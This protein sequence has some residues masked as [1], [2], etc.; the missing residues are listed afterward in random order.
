[1][2]D[3]PRIVALVPMKGH[4]ERVPNKNFR[5]FHGKPLYRWIV[6]SLLE[7]PEIAEVIINTDARETF[8]A[9]GVG[10]LPRVRL[11]DRPVELRGDFVSMNKVLGD[12]VA[13]VPADIY[14]M[15]HS[16]NPLLRSGT[17]RSAIAKYREVLADGTGDSVFAVNRFQTRFYRAD[18][19]AV[20]HDPQ[21]LIRTQDLEPWFEENSNLYIFSAASFAA[22]NARIGARP[23]MFVTPAA[24][25]LDIDDQA[26]WELA[27]AVAVGRERVR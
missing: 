20:N 23:Q 3:V 21:N 1:M 7:L 17:I 13:N 8:E 11:R 25:S 15:T 2:S 6:D 10:A 5:P 26:G 19:S 24:E 18:G 12:D 16:T 27:E 4:S 9:Q 14:V 22:T